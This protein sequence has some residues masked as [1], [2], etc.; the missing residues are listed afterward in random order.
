MLHAKFQDNR[1]SDYD[2]E[3]FKAFLPYMGVVSILVM[4]PWAFIQTFVFDSAEDA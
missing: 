3:V 4:Q 1:D 2:K